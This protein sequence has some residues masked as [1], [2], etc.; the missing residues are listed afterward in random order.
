MSESRVLDQRMTA[1]E[2]EAEGEKLVSRQIL[3][4]T[5]RNTAD[6]ATMRADVRE[7]KTDVAVLKADVAVL[8]ADGATLKSDVH[9]L[10]SQFASYPALMA[11]TMR[12][13]LRER[14][15]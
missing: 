3:E 9:T 8:K 4:H 12:K 6:L 14:D 7:L 11:E 5:R 13:V 15:R 1:L 2:Q 10:K